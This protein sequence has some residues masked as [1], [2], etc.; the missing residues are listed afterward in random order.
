M[1]Q[2]LKVVDKASL[3]FKMALSIPD[4]SNLHE[5]M[6]IT[7]NNSSTPLAEIS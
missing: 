3:Q 6:I 1:K 4:Q 5:F 2:A 7:L